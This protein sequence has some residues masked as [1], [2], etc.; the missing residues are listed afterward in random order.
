MKSIQFTILFTI[1][2]ASLCSQAA[3]LSFNGNV[4]RPWSENPGAATGL[5]EIYVLESLTG[6]SATFTLPSATSTI[7]V[8]TWGAQGAAY[9]TEIPSNLLSRNGNQVTVNT[10]TPDCGYT[11][12]ADGRSTY[13]WI[14]DH[15]AHPYQANSLTP[16]AEQD[17]GRATLDF[18]GSADAITYHGINGRSWTLSRGLTL[19]YST[20][21]FDSQTFSYV[22]STATTELEAIRNSII[23]VDAPLCD[24]YFTLSGDR[25]MRFWGK[26]SEIESSRYTATSV[27]AEV[28]AEQA[29]REAENEVKVETDGLGGSA[30]V[31][32]TFSAAVSDAVMFHEWQFSP[33]QDF[34][35]IT[36]RTQ[37]L[38]FTQ[39][40][41][42]MGT[43]YARFITANA[44]ATCST[45]SETFTIYIG[46]SFLRCPNA[47]SPGATE[48]VNDEWRVSYKSSTSFECYI[49]NRWGQKMTVFRDPSKGW[50]GR[51]KGKLVPAGVYYYVIKAKGSDGKN[52][53]LSGDINIVG[54]TGE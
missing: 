32:I 41:T 47:F 38:S 43:T 33:D 24:T 11:F 17:C 29:V 35:D 3:S 19:T 12:T 10:L 52:Y 9:A 44:D 50:D 48:G 28:K 53:N 51:Y 5:E 30:P 42:E 15:S 2:T 14:V 34:Y 37:Q 45:E 40:F 1:L 23:S 4:R 7:S 46:E 39:T 49:F 6:V 36:M 18:S 21:T 31:E 13:F 8:A 20:L 25:F 16:S 22:S 26:E 54:Y 27:A